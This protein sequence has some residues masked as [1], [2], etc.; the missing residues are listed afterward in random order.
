MMKPDFT[1]FG[2]A[3]SFG[4]WVKEILK[5]AGISVFFGGGEAEWIKYIIN[6]ILC[7][8]VSENENLRTAGWIKLKIKIN[9]IFNYR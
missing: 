9:F 2:N 5:S 8:P 4:V 7:L 3:C 6:V 1:F